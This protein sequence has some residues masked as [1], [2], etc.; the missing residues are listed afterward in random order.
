MERSRLSL[1]AAGIFVGLGF[2]AGVGLSAGELRNLASQVGDRLAAVAD[3]GLG[4][5]KIY[6]V[7]TRAHVVEIAATDSP[8]LPTLSRRIG[9]QLRSPDL[10]RVGLQFL[11]ARVLPFEDETTAQLI[12]EQAG[13]QRVS[14]VLGSSKG[15]DAT[16]LRFKTW[17]ELTSV[18]WIEGDSAFAL[19]GATSRQELVRAADAV[20]TNYW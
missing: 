20:Y 2:I 5:H 15:A 8:C 4:A 12:Y 10:S 11:G 17:N 19:T 1:R 3:F 14:L 16:S 13:G 7:E 6:S 18:F 9:V